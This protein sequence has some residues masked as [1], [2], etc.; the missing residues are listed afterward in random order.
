MPLLRHVSLSY[1]IP[2]FPT[3][4]SIGK[5]SSARWLWHDMACV[6]VMGAVQTATIPSINSPKISRCSVTM[7]WESLKIAIRVYLFIWNFYCVFDCYRHNIY[8]TPGH[9]MC[10]PSLFT[11][12]STTL[13]TPCLSTKQG[14]IKYQFFPCL[15]LITR[16]W[17]RKVVVDV[18]CCWP[19]RSGREA[20]FCLCR[21]YGLTCQSAQYFPGNH[22][23]VLFIIS[24][25]SQ[26]SEYM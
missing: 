7:V 10:Y 25:K 22:C 21:L 13:R 16:G 8:Y 6:N 4:D 2:V 11:C 12:G 20:F 14:R 1:L 19:A 23:L 18:I 26:S 3:A 5:M 15:A 17:V 24:H 9:C